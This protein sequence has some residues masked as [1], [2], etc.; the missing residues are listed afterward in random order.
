MAIQI[1]IQKVNTLTCTNDLIRLTNARAF[2]FFGRRVTSLIVQH[3]ILTL[4]RTKVVIWHFVM[5]F[6]F[7]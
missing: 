3:C 5:E 2:L 1:H 6:Y 7:G 4:F